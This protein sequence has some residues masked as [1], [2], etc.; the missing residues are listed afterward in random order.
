M[1]APVSGGGPAAAERRLLV[2]VGGPDDAVAR[3]RPVFEAY[4][5]PILQLGGVGRG[6]VAK[7][8]NNLVF[9]AQVAVALDTFAFA[10]GLGLDRDA[11]AEVLASGSGGSR[12][13]ALMAQMGFDTSG[14]AQAVPLLRKDVDIVLELAA[15]AGVPAPALLDDL[16][17]GGP[18]PVGRVTGGRGVGRR[19][20]P[21]R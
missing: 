5:A 17:R 2:M 6:Q 13:A 14:M 8:L 1:D 12:A 3:C 7:V 21:R 20:T 10:D 11:L 19:P 9:T 16:A 4:G 18:P 15:A